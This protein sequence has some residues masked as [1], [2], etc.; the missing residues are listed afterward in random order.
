MPS[1]N[2]LCNALLKYGRE[3]I[4]HQRRVS[5]LIVACITSVPN[6]LLLDTKNSLLN[7]ILSFTTE[8]VQV[9]CS[10]VYNKT[11]IFS[12]HSP[13]FVGPFD[14][15]AVPFTG[16][17]GAVVVPFAG[18]FD[19]AVLPFAGPLGSAAEP[20][21]GPLDVHIAP[22]KASAWVPSSIVFGV[23]AFGERWEYQ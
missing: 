10:A 1:L 22:F 15:A 12:P 5:T 11:W 21:D 16:L 18:R 9:V 14:V 19:V 17:L 13:H 3:R 4:H 23:L 2:L 20:F 7:L 8:E 6:F